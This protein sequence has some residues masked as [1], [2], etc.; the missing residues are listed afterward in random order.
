MISAL[1]SLTCSWRRLRRALLAL[2][3]LLGAQLLGTAFGS[4]RLRQDTLGRAQFGL[5]L[6]RLQLEINLI[7]RRQ[8]LADID[9]LPDFNKALRDLAGNAEAHVR[10][11]AG[12]NGA[13]KTALGGLGLVMDRRHQ[14]RGQERQRQQQAVAGQ[15]NQRRRHA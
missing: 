8:R 5:G 7:E 4:G 6:L 1:T 14:H 13:D 12:A 15:R 9:H 2:R 3:G 11:D 10:L